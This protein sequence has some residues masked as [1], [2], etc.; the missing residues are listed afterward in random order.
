MESTPHP[1]PRFF[2]LFFRS[3]TALQ[4]FMTFSN[5]IWRSFLPNFDA[6]EG[7]GQ[8]LTIVKN[9][10]LISSPRLKCRIDDWGKSSYEADLEFHQLINHIVC[11]GFLSVAS[12]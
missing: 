1:H 5:S 2:K 3:K 7:V 12:Q 11:S 6:T 8:F 10:S 4:H 9:E